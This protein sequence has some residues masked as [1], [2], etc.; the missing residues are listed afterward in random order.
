MAK[1]DS[2]IDKSFIIALAEVILGINEDKIPRSVVREQ[3]YIKTKIGG[4]HRTKRFYEVVVNLEQHFILSREEDIIWVLDRDA[5]RDI[6]V[7][8][9]VPRD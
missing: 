2:K 3:W 6:V 9:W 7:N 8:R 4:R 1:Y 5:L